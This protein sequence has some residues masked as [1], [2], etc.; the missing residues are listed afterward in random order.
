MDHYAND[1][2]QVK[3]TFL[4]LSAFSVIMTVLIMLSIMSA[5]ACS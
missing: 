3:L 2:T 5:R 4:G 1:D